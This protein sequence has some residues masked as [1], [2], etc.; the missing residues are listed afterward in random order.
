MED[1]RKKTKETSR[2]SSNHVIVIA[3]CASSDGA[4]VLSHARP[5]PNAAISARVLLLEKADGLAIFVIVWAL[6]QLNEAVLWTHPTARPERCPCSKNG[7][8]HRD[9]W[10]LA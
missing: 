1:C 5:V 9:A 3:A 8:A 6:V 10:S 2:I 4:S 7:V